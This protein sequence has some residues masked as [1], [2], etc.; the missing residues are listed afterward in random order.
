MQTEAKY[1]EQWDRVKRWWTRVRE[2]SLGRSHVL[3]PE[4]GE[5][6]IFAFFLNCYHLKDWVKNDPASGELK[7][8]VEA[9]VKNSQTLSICG[10][11][12]NGLKHLARDPKRVRKNA[13]FGPSTH[14]IVDFDTATIAIS[15]TI[16]SDSGT[17]DAFH[18]ASECLVEWERF[19]SRKRKRAS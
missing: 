9:Y 11:L 8:L 10:E 15:P 17:F 7:D 12:C 1:L 19:F 4:F 14:R 18:L 2:V 3:Y 16:V 6:E 13:K 5:D